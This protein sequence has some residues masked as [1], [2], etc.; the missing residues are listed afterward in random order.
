M[1]YILLTATCWLACFFV[2][3]QNFQVK[4]L[5]N[6]VGKW[7]GKLTYLDYTSG[8]PYSMLANITVSLTHDNKGFITSYEYPKEP[9]ENSKDTTFVVGKLFGKDNIVEFKNVSNGGF[10]FITEIDGED[11]NENKKAILRHTYK[12]NLNTFSIMKEVNF[13]GGKEWIKRN[14]YLLN[15]IAN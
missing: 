3:A 1:K 2:N 11:G 9:H 12:L 5:G 4:D 13:L 7:E 15:K 14:E 8:K 10:T 6:A